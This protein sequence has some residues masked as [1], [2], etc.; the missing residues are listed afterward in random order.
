MR[1]MIYLNGPRERA[2]TQHHRGPQVL[3]K[4]P[5]AAGSPEVPTTQRLMKMN[6]TTRMATVTLNPT[7]TRTTLGHLEAEEVA[8]RRGRTRA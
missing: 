1:T 2:G 5:V 6:T 4:P 8:H 7:M 3:P